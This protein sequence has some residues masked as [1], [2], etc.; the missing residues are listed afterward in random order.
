[1]ARCNA[2]VGS[3][4]ILY[5]RAAAPIDRVSQTDKT[6]WSTWHRP[7]RFARISG[8]GT[9]CIRRALVRR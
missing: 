3:R 9:R 5:G 8:I 2:E 4:S 6:G 1:M 7:L